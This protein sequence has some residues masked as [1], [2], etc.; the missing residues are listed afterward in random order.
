MVEQAL[1]KHG[2]ALS[3]RHPSVHTAVQ[4]VA[5]GWDW[6][7]GY[8]KGP[9]T[10]LTHGGPRSPCSVPVSVDSTLR[11][12]YVK[13]SGGT[14][15]RVHD[16]V[17]GAKSFGSSRPHFGGRLLSSTATSGARLAGVRT[18]T[19]QRSSATKG[20]REIMMGICQNR[21]DLPRH[22]SA[23]CQECFQGTDGLLSHKDA[24]AVGKRKAHSAQLPPVRGRRLDNLPGFYDTYISPDN[25]LLHDCLMYSRSNPKQI[26][27]VEQDDI[28]VVAKVNATSRPT[29][30]CHAGTRPALCPPVDGPGEMSE[31]FE[32][33]EKV[34][35]HG[36]SLQPPR[37]RSTLLLDIH[38]PRV[39][40]ATKLVDPEDSDAEFTEDDVNQ[41]DIQMDD[42]FTGKTDV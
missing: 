29:G 36:Y 15:R 10:C 26:E 7:Q 18:F 3:A 17:D 21:G 39:S 25:K 16:V 42:V 35:L 23:D 5:G 9:N 6:S 19:R 1:T 20:E 12:S 13:Q 33:G 4:G 8:L 24:W 34:G 41:T 31:L 30:D 11:R 32:S 14:V 40:S 37:P 28:D 38:L 27:V 22:V 2:A